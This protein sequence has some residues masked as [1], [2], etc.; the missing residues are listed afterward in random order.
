MSGILG[1][2]SPGIF[3]PDIKRGAR[4]LVQIPGS[5]AE[6]FSPC[7]GVALA[8]VGLKGRTDI[9]QDHKSGILVLI[10]GSALSPVI[11]YRKL[12]ATEIL[13]IYCQDGLK[14]FEEFEG[15]F[16]VALID[17]HQQKLHI[18]NDRLGQ[19]PLLYTQGADW[20][21]FGS[22]AKAIFP[23]TDMDPR[24]STEAIIQFL[25]AG[26]AF[27]E[28][29]MFDGLSV[30]KPASQLTLGLDDLKIHS[31]R[32]WTLQYEPQDSVS[33]SEALTKLYDAVL[34]GHQ[35]T[36]GQGSPIYDLLLTGGWDSR[37]ILEAL[38]HIGSKPQTAK[39]WGARD[40]LEGS[41]PAIA[42]RLAIEFGI[43]FHFFQYDIERLPNTLRP[44]ICI[45]ELMNDNLGWYVE[46]PQCYGELHSSDVDF[47]L[48]GDEIWGWEGHVQDEQGAISRVLP[49]SLPTSVTKILR[50]EHKGDLQVGY[51][52]SIRSILADSVSRN[53]N[54]LKD[55][56]YFNI[57]VNRFIFSLGYFRELMVPQRRPF[58]TRPVLDVMCRFPREMRTDKNGYIAMLKNYM[59]KSASLPKNTVNSVANWQHLFRT[60]EQIR[61]T[62][63]QLLTHERISKGVLG[64]ILDAEQLLL[65]RDR[66][67]SAR[68]QQPEREN[69]FK[70]RL[71]TYVRKV[72]ERTPGL[73]TFTNFIRGNEGS[74][75]NTLRR[76]ALCAALQD[77]L[78]RFKTGL[79]ELLLFQEKSENFTQANH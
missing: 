47:A 49:P 10:Q 21:C 53:P 76:V 7:P 52:K 19:L 15:S 79:P 35:I 66:F 1:L 56:A 9:A 43:D 44:W 37:G 31:R 46:L 57:R 18:V 63:I 30:L 50:Q 4:T 16:V 22:Q 42:R 12:S 3:V 5:K 68:P 61:Q 77:E 27:G 38:D 8:A 67:F 45:S 26:Y 60:D 41:D 72:I 23:I 58:L 13:E 51:L 6:Y 11:P 28:I 54:D 32:Y 2:I 20:F 17:Q 62:F 59:K 55:F 39:S 14:G 71:R 36:L 33:R 75:F 65:V 24:L 73:G 25:S 69:F 48:L 70:A 78:P 29:S 34:V 40:D 74:D 64:E